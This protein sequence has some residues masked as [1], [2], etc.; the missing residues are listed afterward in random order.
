[1]PTEQET[2]EDWPGKRLGLPQYGERSIARPGRRMVGV[3]IDWAIA[4]VLTFA[5]VERQDGWIILGIFA[6][7]HVIF[8]PTLGGSIGHL[9][10]G[11][12]VVPLEPVWIGVVKPVIRTALLCLAIPALVWDVDQRG[13]HDRIAGTVLVRRSTR[14]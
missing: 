10:T 5:I 9:V 7:M 1:M 8:I 13:L 11:L 3:L 4:T 6:A 2:T 14:R 12:R